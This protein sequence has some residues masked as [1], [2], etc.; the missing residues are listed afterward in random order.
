L[1]GIGIIQDIQLEL[2]GGSNGKQKADSINSSNKRILITVVNVFFH[3]GGAINTSSG[4]KFISIWLICVLNFEDN[5][6]SQNC[7]TS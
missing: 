2:S 7:F 5:S 1:E 6:V 3:G 4:V